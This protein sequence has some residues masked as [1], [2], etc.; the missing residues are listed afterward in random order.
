MTLHWRVVNPVKRLV[1]LSG[2]AK[3]HRAQICDC[4]LLLQQAKDEVIFLCCPDY[5]EVSSHADSGQVLRASLHF[6]GW[7]VD[8][9][10]T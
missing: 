1:G 6:R 4:L 10:E 7:D 9:E 2:K 5:D 8:Y 3:P